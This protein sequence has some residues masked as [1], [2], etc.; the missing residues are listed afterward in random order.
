MA[1]DR[2]HGDLIVGGNLVIGTAG[3]GLYGSVE[4]TGGDAGPCRARLDRRRGCSL[5][6]AEGLPRLA[7]V[8]G[9][10]ARTSAAK[11]MAPSPSNASEA[12]WRALA[13]SGRYLVD[14]GGPSHHKLAVDLGGTFLQAAGHL[15]GRARPWSAL[16][17]PTSSL[18]S[19][20]RRGLRRGAPDSLHS[21]PHRLRFTVRAAFG[22]QSPAS[23][24]EDTRVGTPSD[25][26]RST[27]R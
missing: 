16:A 10:M 21:G 7:L 2:S 27:M 19:L 20:G 5:T 17:A 23:A 18:M 26:G 22:G 6:T 24:V 14:I 11:R 4:P 3:I 8:G 25:L 12:S 15:A 1:L 13:I 9:R